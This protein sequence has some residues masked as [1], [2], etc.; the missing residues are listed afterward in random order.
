MAEHS[1]L[2]A[3]Y[4][5]VLHQGYLDLL[6]TQPNAPIGVLGTD[7]LSRRFNYLRKDIR[8]L[9][10]EAAANLLSATGRSV[11]VIGETALRD[12]M[13]TTHLTMPD[14]DV[15]HTLAEEFDVS[16]HFEP[17]FLRWDRE[18]T[19]TNT[20]VIPDRVIQLSD[21]DPIIRALYN[22]A[23][24]SPNWWRHVGAALWDTEGHITQLTY[25]T[26]TPTVYSSAI[27]GDPRITAQ[28]GE[29][30]ERSIDIHAEAKL[31]AECAKTGNT[32]DG[33][34][35]FV[36]TFPC[37]NCAKIIAE[38]GITAC[39]FVEG[40]ATIDGQ[41]ILKNNAVEIVKVETEVPK[42]DARRLRPYPSR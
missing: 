12:A 3:G 33:T 28:R 15:S 23:S 5:P 25:N 30:I 24:K 10:P 29:A 16:P 37:S 39:Y 41:N 22:E 34:S 40:Y 26:S 18:N 35:I 36:T 13:S 21:D 20:L 9:T 31:I 38:S 19:V 7:V 14:D 4:F 2:I 11:R 8:A 17:V 27:D 42:T 6:G 32:T 1:E